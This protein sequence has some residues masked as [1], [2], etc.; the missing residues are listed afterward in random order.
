VTPKL[1]R[2]SAQVPAGPGEL[3]D[4]ARD[5]HRLVPGDEDFV[6][7]RRRGAGHGRAVILRVQRDLARG[8]IRR[9]EVSFAAL[10]SWLHCGSSPA[11][12]VV[13][14]EPLTAMVRGSPRVACRVNASLVQ[15]IRL[16]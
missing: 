1:T 11:T 2:G 16:T 3:D 10:L 7:V 6:G 15:S 14:G 5:G 13:L 4:A 12:M 9:L 8:L